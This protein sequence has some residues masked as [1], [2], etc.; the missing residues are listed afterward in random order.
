MATNKVWLITGAGRGLGVDIAKAAMAAGH[1][2]VATGRNTAKVAKALGESADLLV[3]KLD[4]T[5][6][7]DA[8]SAVKATVDR[9]GRIDVLVNNA[10]N[11]YAGFFEELTPEQM[12][13]QLSTSLVGPMNVTR[14]V[15]AVMRKQRSGLIITISSTAG[16]I[17]FEFGSAYAASKFG[18][19][20][21]MQSLQAEVEPFGI[22]TITVNPGF[23]RTELLTE[24]STNF[25]ERTIADY[26][27]RRTKQ[28][29]FWKGYNGQQSGD[30][31]KLAE[32]LITIS[33]QEKPPRRF[34][35]G[36][37]AVATA[38]QVAATLLQQ[39]EAY[40][41]LSSSLAYEDAA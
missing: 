34:L 5:K 39:T 41:K 3:V 32:A 22:N 16:L 26:N 31:A 40:R 18:L 23:F 38:E 14:P 19:E 29:E 6:P 8:E 2:V 17:G 33:S 24:E 12:E 11:F 13:R 4:I 15:L 9:F 28:M 10:A 37:D 21:W 30:P 35:A 1:K 36:A 25:A 20:G 27:E 7:S